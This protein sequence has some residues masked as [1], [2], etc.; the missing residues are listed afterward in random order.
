VVEIADGIVL[1][2]SEQF[3]DIPHETSKI[4]FLIRAFPTV[5]AFF[6]VV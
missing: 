3:P 4:G 5:A 2:G 6:G 1:S